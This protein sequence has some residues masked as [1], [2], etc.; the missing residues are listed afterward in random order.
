MSSE[1]KGV[2]AF[3]EGGPERFAAVL[4]VPESKG[5]VAGDRADWAALVWKEGLLEDKSLPW[6]VRWRFHYHVAGKKSV[7]DFTVKGPIPRDQVLSSLGVIAAMTAAR[8]G[9]E[10]R[11][12][13]LKGADVKELMEVLTTLPWVNVKT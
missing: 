8:N 2:F 10:V 13:D 6:L 11:H 12:V 5:L 9:T 3:A 1:R 4:F 7:Y